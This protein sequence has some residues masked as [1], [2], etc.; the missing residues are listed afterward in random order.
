MILVERE[1]LVN[2]N[3]SRFLFAV[4]PKA[5]ASD[6]TANWEGTLSQLRKMIDKQLASMKQVM[7]RT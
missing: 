1:S 6:E 4:T 2:K 7:Y 3:L 5:M